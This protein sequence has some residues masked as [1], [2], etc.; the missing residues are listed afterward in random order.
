MPPRPPN[1]LVPPITTAVMVSRLAPTI[2]F[3]LAVPA[4]PIS[5]QAREAVDQPRH[6]VDAEEHAVDLDANQ[7]GGLDVIADG[8]Q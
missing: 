4:R 5:T 2:A 3:G 7:P 1:R 6:G 8:V